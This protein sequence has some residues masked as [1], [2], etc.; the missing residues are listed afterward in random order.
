MEDG[1]FDVWIT[2]ALWDD[3]RTVRLVEV[4]NTVDGFAYE[5]ELVLLPDTD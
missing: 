3:V 1:G 4:W 5:Q 2:D